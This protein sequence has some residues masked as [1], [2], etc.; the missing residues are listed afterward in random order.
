MP[1]LP[2]GVIDFATSQ[3]FSN[4]LSRSTTWLVPE[5]TLATTFA[6]TLG[7]PAS[8]IDIANIENAVNAGGSV[9]TVQWSLAHTQEAADRFNDVF[10][11]ILGRTLDGTAIKTA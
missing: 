10:R 1:N 6:N 3:A 7:H 8:G 11:S 2:G 9:A 5:S 4:Y